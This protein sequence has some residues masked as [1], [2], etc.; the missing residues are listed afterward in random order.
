VSGAATFTDLGDGRYGVGGALR[1]ETVPRLW[2]ET[3]GLFGVAG[4]LTVDLGAVTEVDSAG[5]ALM[6]EWLREARRAGGGLRFE[7]IPEPMQAIARV[8]RLSELLQ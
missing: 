3:R 2:A 5:L 8:S 6:V 4:R 7:R 1:F